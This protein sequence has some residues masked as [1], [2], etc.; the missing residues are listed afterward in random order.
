MELQTTDDRDAD[1]L[2]NTQRMMAR[3]EEIIRQYP[4]Q[5]MWQYDIFRDSLPLADTGR[6]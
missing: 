1:L 4:E 5:Y 2:V 6:G 3:L